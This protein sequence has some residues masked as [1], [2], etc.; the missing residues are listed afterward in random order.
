[1]GCNNGTAATAGT[2]GESLISTISAYANFTT[3]ATYQALTSLSITAGEW[4]VF[5]TVT[6]SGNGSTLTAAANGIFLVGSTSASATGTTEG[7]NIGYIAGSFNA[8]DKETKSFTFPL[9]L[10]ATTPYYL[11]AQM[12]F[13]LGNPQFVCT[14]RA[15]RRR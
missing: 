9:S 5:A 4:D 8:A 10:T 3:T 6:F 12:T 13:T 1:M 7:L 2:V 11:N 14:L 15:V